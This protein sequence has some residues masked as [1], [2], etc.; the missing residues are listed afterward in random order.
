MNES[1]RIV[2]RQLQYNQIQVLEN[3]VTSP[4][5][6]VIVTDGKTPVILGK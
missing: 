1:T 3:L 4:N 6:K 5:A 2:G